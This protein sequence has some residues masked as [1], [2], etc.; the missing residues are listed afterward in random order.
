MQETRFS[1]KNFQ[2]IIGNLLRYGIW[3]S[4]STAATGGFLYLFRHGQERIHYENFAEKDLDIFEVFSGIYHGVLDGKAQSI[5]YLGIVMLF[6]TPVMRI[7]FSL[8]SFII[9]KDYTYVGI[10]LVVMII[11]ATSVYLGFGH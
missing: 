8:I 5:I 11:I 2:F 3:S 6:L 10:T 1:D 9:E 7:V 4:L